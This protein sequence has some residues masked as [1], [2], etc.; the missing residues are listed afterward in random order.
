VIGAAA[1]WLWIDRRAVLVAQACD[2]VRSLVASGLGLCRAIEI[3]AAKFRGRKLDARRFLRL[4]ASTLQ[5]IWYSFNGDAGASAFR[6]RHRRRVRASSLCDQRF[7]RPLIQACTERGLMV[8]RVPIFA[9]QPAPIRHLLAL[10]AAKIANQ[11]LRQVVSA[12]HDSMKL[13]TQSRV[14]RRRGPRGKI[15]SLTASQRLTIDE[16]LKENLT[17]SEI[18]TRIKN[19]F[20]VTI[21]AATLCAYYRARNAAKKPRTDLRPKMDSLSSDQR[22]TVN[23]WLK[24][25]RSYCEIRSRIREQFGLSVSTATLSVYYHSRQSEIFAGTG[26]NGN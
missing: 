25:R 15:D 19:Q 16:W 4:S 13:M 20:S 14:P 2:Y 17:Y 6:L 22:L 7:L 12:N 11:Q 23:Q 18:V 26:G 10:V 8:T 21:S 3:S 1:S 5:R 24:Q 9:K